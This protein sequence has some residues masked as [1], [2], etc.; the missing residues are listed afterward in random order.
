[1]KCY[2]IFTNSTRPQKHYF[3]DQIWRQNETY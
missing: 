3:L 2:R 1:M